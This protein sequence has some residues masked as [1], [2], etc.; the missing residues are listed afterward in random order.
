MLEKG[1]FFTEA[2]L[3]LDIA[4]VYFLL[5]PFLLFVSIGYAIRGNY[6]KHINS[7]I[8]IFIVSMIMVII[9]EVG[10]R[11]KGGFFVLMEQ[12]KFSYTPLLIFL[13]IHISIAT[14]T[15]LSWIYLIFTSYISYK[16]GELVAHHAKLAKLTVG[17][18]C[19]TSTMGVIIYAAIFVFK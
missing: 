19:I 7:Q 2:P 8:A 6:K 16:K 5:L 11:M 10:M 13:M 1:F 4:T 15:I 12:S 18:I 9:F 17:G 3:F 14:M